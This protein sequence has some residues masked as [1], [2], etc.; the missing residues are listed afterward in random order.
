ME[1][2]QRCYDVMVGRITWSLP[3]ASCSTCASHWLR[4]PRAVEKYTVP[5]LAEAR[6]SI[7]F[8]I[9]TSALE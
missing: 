7:A 8:E 6:Y 4:S 9:D 5:M 1:E 3:I 2:L